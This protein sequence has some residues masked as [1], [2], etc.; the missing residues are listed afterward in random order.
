MMLCL[1]I[2]MT[3]TMNGFIENTNFEYVEGASRMIFFSDKFDDNCQEFAK[4]DVTLPSIVE[5]AIE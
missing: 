5:N 3:T 2:V 1:D 4:E